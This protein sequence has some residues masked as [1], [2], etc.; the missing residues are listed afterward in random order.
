MFLWKVCAITKTYANT[1]FLKRWWSS[2]EQFEEFR[3]LMLRMKLLPLF[4]PEPFNYMRD[5]CSHFLTAH[6]RPGPSLFTCIMQLYLLSPDKWLF[7]L[8]PLCRW[9]T[10]APGSY[11]ICLPDSR[12]CPLNHPLIQL[13]CAPTILY[14]CLYI[15]YALY[16]WS[17]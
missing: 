13:P 1:S 9:E 8:C 5:I 10:E 3:L 15:I 6:T 4:P 16:F 7:S 12:S 17:L 11:M 14:I 2:E